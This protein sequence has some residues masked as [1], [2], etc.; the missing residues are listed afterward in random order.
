MLSPP[1]M[2]EPIRSFYERCVITPFRNHPATPGWIA[3][4]T[5]KGWQYHLNTVLGRGRASFDQP[6]NQLSAEERVLVYCYYYMQM[7]VASNLDVFQELQNHRADAPFEQCL[8]LDFGCGPLTLGV[9]IAW[10]H[11]LRGSHQANGRVLLDYV[12]I[13]NSQTMG[14]MAAR[15]QNESQLFHEKSS[16]H[17]LQ[18][19]NNLDLLCSQIDQHASVL[20]VDRLEVVLH[21]SYF[22]ESTSLNLSRFIVTAQRLLSRYP[23]AQFWLVYQNPAGPGFQANWD[24]FKKALP[25][26][27]PVCQRQDAIAY[28]NSTNRQGAIKSVKLA[29]E[30]MSRPRP[31]S[32]MGGR[33]SKSTSAD[34]SSVCEFQ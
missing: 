24:R 5:S 12:G 13:E 23:H 33:A 11:H 19:C 6:F 31:T 4:I 26:V 25:R 32:I 15:I 20:S 29:W 7:H 30:I 28:V 10:L 17:I 3:E 22:F 21:L 34:P 9:A 2:P 16:F 18:D 1:A 14:H 8:L 27:Q